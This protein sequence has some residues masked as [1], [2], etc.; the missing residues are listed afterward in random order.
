MAHPVLLRAQ[1]EFRGKTSVE[2]SGM[3]KTQ[4]TTA[5]Q[6]DTNPPRENGTPRDA[7]TLPYMHLAPY[8]GV[9]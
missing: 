3:T 2:N 6:M 7:V 5:S 8:G 4:C 1:E 9:V